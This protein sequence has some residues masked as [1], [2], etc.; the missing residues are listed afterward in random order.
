MVIV[1]LLIVVCSQHYG[2]NIGN[3]DYQLRVSLIDAVASSES[4][5]MWQLYHQYQEHGGRMRTATDSVASIYDGSKQSPLHN[6]LPATTY[7]TIAFGGMYIV[8]YCY[9]NIQDKHVIQTRLIAVMGILA[10]ALSLIS[11]QSGL[12]SLMKS[13]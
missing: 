3:L 9:A 7:A 10:T 12:I 11:R 6:I 13:K 8:Q 2:Y 5:S 4:T 1:A